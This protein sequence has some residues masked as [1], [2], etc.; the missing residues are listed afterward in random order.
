[1]T[2]ARKLPVLALVAFLIAATPTS[3]IAAKKQKTEVKFVI[4]MESPCDSWWDW[5]PWSCSD[6]SGKFRASGAVSDRG[7]ASAPEFGVDFRIRLDGKKGKGSITISVPITDWDWTAW[8]A[9][10]IAGGTGV[11][12]GLSGGGSADVEFTP[13][14]DRYGVYSVR[15]DLHLRGTID[16][17]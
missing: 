2:L 13:L 8:T 17:G 6:W 3:A 11:Y 12:A 9:F 4:S 7:P 15:A 16:G 1:M 14:G 10:E 5:G